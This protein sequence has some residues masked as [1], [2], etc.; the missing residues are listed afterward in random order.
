MGNKLNTVMWILLIKNRIN[1]VDKIKWIKNYIQ[2]ILPQR[3]CFDNIIASLIHFQPLTVTW[4]IIRI[5]LIFTFLFQAIS[6]RILCTFCF[7][8]VHCWQLTCS[9]HKLVNTCPIFFVIFIFM[10]V[11]FS[12]QWYWLCWKSLIDHCK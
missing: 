4:A 11:S 5:Q 12:H 10:V 2:N 9:C 1:K 6:L 3:Y 8:Q 7:T